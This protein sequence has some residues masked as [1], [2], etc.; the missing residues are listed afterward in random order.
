MMPN[1]EVICSD[2]MASLISLQTVRNYI[3]IEIM[4]MLYRLRHV[5]IIVPILVG[6]QRMLIYQEMKNLIKWLKIHLIIIFKFH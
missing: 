2:S 3:F 4:N 1:R 5:G 6:F